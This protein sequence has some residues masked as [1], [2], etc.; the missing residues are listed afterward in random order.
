MLYARVSVLFIYCTAH[1]AEGAYPEG[2][3]VRCRLNVECENPGYPS[4]VATLSSLFCVGLLHMQRL[5]GE[6]GERAAK[7][8]EVSQPAIPRGRG[9]TTGRTSKLE[10][11][12]T[13][14]GRVGPPQKPRS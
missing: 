4:H 5:T 8:R 9:K 2:I 6:D 12:S 3:P 14:R 10:H 7:N 13:T 1:T 11:A